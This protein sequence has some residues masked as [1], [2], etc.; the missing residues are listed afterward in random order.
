ME[1]K[2]EKVD[3]CPRIS[4]SSEVILVGDSQTRGLQ[5]LLAA[6]LHSM[7]D[8]DVHESSISIR[9][10]EELWTGGNSTKVV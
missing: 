1:K 8:D 10:P 6:R 9:S 4:E 3:I 2:K 5:L 7:V